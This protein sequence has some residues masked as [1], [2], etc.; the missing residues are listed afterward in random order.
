MEKR[1]WGNSET[2]KYSEDYKVREL[3]IKPG[4]NISSQIHKTCSEFWVIVKGKVKVTIGGDTQLMQ[5][6]QHIYIPSNCKH[7]I[8]NIT[9]DIV[10][11]VEIQVGKQI[12]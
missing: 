12:N 1:E 3:T 8:E 2:F 9:K 11:L 7:K 5:R 10:I 4:K 6:N